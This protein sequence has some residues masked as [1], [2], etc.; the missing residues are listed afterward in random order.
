MDVN[1]LIVEPQRLPARSF[2]AKSDFLVDMPGARVEGVNLKSY[3]V[4][5]KLVYAVP[6]NQL[7][8][9]TAE[10]PTA[11]FGPQESAEA[12]GA[13]QLVP[14]AEHDFSNHRIRR[15]I[16]HGED[17]TVISG[18]PAFVRHT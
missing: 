1:P 17:Q 15:L 8:R 3:S 13:I 2:V 18:A 12:A 5:T 6:D 10:P 14:V 7:S 11:A 4:K 16:N 9:F